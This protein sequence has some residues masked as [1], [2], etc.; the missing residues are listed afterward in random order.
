MKTRGLF[1]LA[2]VSN[3]SFDPELNKTFV[4]EVESSKKVR[5]IMQADGK[6]SK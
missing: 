1:S 5:K 4:Y 6:D 3:N 2:I